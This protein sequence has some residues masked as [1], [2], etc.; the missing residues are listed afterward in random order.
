MARIFESPHRAGA[1]RKPQLAPLPMQGCGQN[2]LR[3]PGA[4]LFCVAL[5]CA[6]PS[7]AGLDL[8]LYARLLAEHTQSV[9]DVAGV[10]VDYAALRGGA[11]DSRQSAAVN[12]AAADWRRLVA[13]LAAADGPGTT[14]AERLAFWINAYNVLAIDMVVRHAPPQSIR[15]I[16]SLLRPV[17]RRPAGMAAGRTRTLHEI[18]HEILRPMG[19]PRVHGA[20]V[21]ASLSCPSLSR[22]PYRPETL[23][24]QLDDGMRRWLADSRKGLR[25][26]R[27]AQTL[28]LNPVFRWFAS[29]FDATGGVPAFV[30]RHAPADAA[31]WLRMR[32]VP[33]R[34]RYLDYD[35]RL[36]TAA[37]PPTPR[38]PPR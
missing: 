31:A 13:S 22:V 30:L 20:I 33:P 34:I 5:L 14:Q 8:A 3:V 32:S 16:G 11:P 19:E 17:W 35:W 24:A 21:C 27:K 15:D 7:A 9:P 18:E 2:S 28:Y 1:P 4:A 26:D 23:D 29:D 38:A 6:P 25:V 10:R 12:N 37:S 36:N